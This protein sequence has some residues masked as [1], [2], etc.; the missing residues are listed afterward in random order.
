MDYKIY[1]YIFLIIF[2]IMIF[3]KVNKKNKKTG[4]KINIEKS[5]LKDYEKYCSFKYQFD[6]KSIIEELLLDKYEHSSYNEKSSIIDEEYKFK[7]YDNEYNHFESRDLIKYTYDNKKKT[8]SIIETSLE[9]ESDNSS[10]FIPSFKGIFGYCDIDFNTHY[11]EIYLGKNKKYLEKIKLDDEEFNSLYEVITSEELIAYKLLTPDNI[12]KLKE[13]KK[14]IPS[15][16]I[17]LSD[18]I[19]YFKID[20]ENIIDGNSKEE[21]LM[22]LYKLDTLLTIIGKLCA[23][24]QKE[25][26]D[27]LS[28]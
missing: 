28:N 17:L 14:T 27:K 20:Y 18:N 1:V 2:L 3:Y 13:I 22:S 16:E 15:L 19:L 10:M 8:L 21:I 9:K 23:E 4:L 26:I 11:K 5:K 25:I 12:V 6:K 7:T 24:A